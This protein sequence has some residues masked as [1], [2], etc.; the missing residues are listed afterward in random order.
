VSGLTERAGPRPGVAGRAEAGGLPLR[1]G[2]NL[3]GGGAGGAAAG[4]ASHCVAGGEV[5]VS[6][7]RVELAVL[8]WLSV[9]WYEGLYF[10]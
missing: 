7:E 8:S 5:K 4:A 1:C 6:S 10:P 3:R 9:L 2:V